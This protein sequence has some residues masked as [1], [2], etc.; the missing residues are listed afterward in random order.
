MRIPDLQVVCVSASRACRIAQL[1]H[2]AYLS[3]YEG[4]QRATS[5]HKHKI[6]L[7]SPRCHQQI[8]GREFL[9]S[10]VSS[11]AVP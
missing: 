1:L 8:A 5:G 7:T 10:P 6:V 3:L 9:P 2:G 11:S 4:D